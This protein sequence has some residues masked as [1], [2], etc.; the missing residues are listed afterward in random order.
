MTDLGKKEAVKPAL[1]EG[2]QALQKNYL[3]KLEVHTRELRRLRE[4]LAKGFL[5]GKDIQQLYRLTHNFSGSGATF[6]FPEIGRTARELNNAL[7]KFLDTPG[8]ERAAIGQSDELRQK[9][10]AC[11]QACRD[12]T[13]K[14]TAP[15]AQMMPALPLSGSVA[16]SENKTIGV[17]APKDG[18]AESL[19]TQLRHFGYNA[20]LSEDL[21]VFTSGEFFDVLIAYSDL[22]ADDLTHLEAVAKKRGSAVIV[23]N[24]REDFDTRLTAV[25]IGAKSYFAPDTDALKIIDKI[26]QLTS[27]A[28]QTQWNVLIVD[29][30]D[31]IAE[32]YAQT[33]QSA[34]MN[35]ST[36]NNPRDCM[37]ALNHSAVDLILIDYT[38]PFCSGQELATIIRQHEQYKSLPIVFMSAQQDIESQ[39][40]N[41][42]L[43]IDDFLVKPF[44]P[45]QLISV[46]GSRAARAAELKSL[47]VRDNF[48][49]LFNHAR[50]LE[51]MSEELMNIQ[52]HGRQTCYA[53]IDIDH[54]KK[55]NDTYGHSAGD[56]VLK[57]LARMLQQQLRRS[58][59]IGR[60]GGEEF[61]ILL[62]NC[63][64]ANAERIIESLRSK[65]AESSYKVGAHDINVTFSGGVTMMD[66]DKSINE[67][68]N[69]ADEAL[70]QSKEGG[71]NRITIV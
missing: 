59:I 26:E 23:M 58:D 41:S 18:V 49:G 54:F 2:L 21:R 46:V 25:Q 20:L 44:T 30:D 19:I 53:I 62:P 34:G 61:G 57:S 50:F 7:K 38:M 71:R 24:S 63:D 32:F 69:I 64:M 39:L 16:A 43:G 42:G 12:A 60:C 27:G 13:S 37:E 47:M 10:E 22:D 66:K 31:M 4:V 14:K 40:I 65:F 11:E 9:L 35:T 36:I 28:K 45:A 3:K 33:L 15:Q 1:N 68:I 52:R 29:D 8:D 48:T 70:Y 56:Q 17:Y 55:I 5:P 51:I 67:T 6:G